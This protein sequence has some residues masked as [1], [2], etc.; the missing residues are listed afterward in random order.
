MKAL[1]ALLALASIAMA[2][3]KDWQA[4]AVEKYPALGVQGSELNQRFVEAAKDRRKANP[5]F[6]AN[7][8][9]PIIL[10]DELAE[11]E[12]RKI[13][14]GD[15]EQRQ[16][17]KAEPTQKRFLEYKAKAEQ[18][19]AEAQHLIGIHYLMSAVSK[20]PKAHDYM[21]AAKW[22]RKA[23]EQGYASAQGNLA[24]RYED[25]EGV[26]KDFVEAYAWYNLASVTHKDSAQNRDELEKKMTTQQVAD[27][28]KRTRELRAM[29]DAKAAK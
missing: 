19:D 18:G 11:A 8:Q 14:K 15:E 23:A 24:V 9:W 21:E 6:F 5:N 4:K 3:E 27:G 10:A 1:F 28:Q 16:A 13:A 7:Q 22:F 12:Q 20:K 25:G 29:I 17:A 26:A 2:A